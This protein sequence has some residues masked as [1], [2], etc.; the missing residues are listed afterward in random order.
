[1]IYQGMTRISTAGQWVQASKPG[2]SSITKDSRLTASGQSS[3]SLR[4][5]QTVQK[6]NEVHVAVCRWRLSMRR[7]EE[8]V[9]ALKN[10]NRRLNEK[11]AFLLRPPGASGTLNTLRHGDA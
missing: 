3:A 2:P 6:Q 11:I 7:A 5:S 9:A 10:R 1:M 8:V 4:A